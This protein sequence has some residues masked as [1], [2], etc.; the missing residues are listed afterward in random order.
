MKIITELTSTNENPIDNKPEIAVLEIN[1]N[2]VNQVKAAQNFIKTS[3][4]ISSVTLSIAP[5][6]Y[7]IDHDEEVEPIS[8][9]NGGQKFLLERASFETCS[10]VVRGETMY[11]RMIPKFMNDSETCISPSFTLRELPQLDKDVFYDVAA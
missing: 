10:L 9:I 4:Q 8:P 2:L 3:S 1:D 6:M 5:E 7:L 11:L